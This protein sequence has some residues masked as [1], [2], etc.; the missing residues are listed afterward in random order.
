ML[1]KNNQLDLNF[2]KYLGLYD[3]IIKPDNFW[4]QLNDRAIIKSKN[5]KPIIEHSVIIIIFFFIL[6][7]HK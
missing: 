1:K 3:I 4:K 5:I 6:P 7:P 2:S